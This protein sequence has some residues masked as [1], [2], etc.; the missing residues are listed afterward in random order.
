[1]YIHVLHKTKLFLDFKLFWLW[2][3]INAV[4]V[5]NYL[6]FFFAVKVQKSLQRLPDTCS[7]VCPCVL[8][9]RAVRCVALHRPV[10]LR[11]G[12]WLYYG[13][14]HDVHADVGLHPL[15]WSVPDCGSNHRPG[16]RSRPGAGE[17]NVFITIMVSVRPPYLLS[18]ACTLK[19]H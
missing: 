10:N 13:C 16:C 4:F 15:L 11:R 19:S 8:P 12:V 2:Y 1:M 18:S 3:I 9:L 5:L 14:G 7:A 6:F 17:N